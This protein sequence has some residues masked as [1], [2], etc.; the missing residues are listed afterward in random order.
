[1]TPPKIVPCELVSRGSIAMRIAGS[2]FMFRIV[3][4]QRVNRK[5]ISAWPLDVRRNKAATAV[6]IAAVADPHPEREAHH[7]RTHRYDSRFANRRG[8]FGRRSG[9]AIRAG[10]TFGL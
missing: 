3:N 4:R 6:S 7:V 9:F 1:M 10:R 5:S 2:E 8:D